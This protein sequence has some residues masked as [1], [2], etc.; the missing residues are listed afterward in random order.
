MTTLYEINWHY[1]GDKFSHCTVTPIKVLREGILPGCTAVSIT[2]RDA[3]GRKFQ[4][5]PDDYFKTEEDAWRQIKKDLL[6]TIEANDKCVETL[7]DETHR[8]FKYL[9]SLPESQ[10]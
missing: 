1:V 10:E 9:C 2:A 4:G 5:S 7:K 3:S 6:Q 8:L